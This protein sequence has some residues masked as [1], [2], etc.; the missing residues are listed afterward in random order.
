MAVRVNY[1]AI[2]D[3][4]KQKAFWT[5]CHNFF[6]ENVPLSTE[7]ESGSFHDKAMDDRGPPKIISIRTSQIGGKLALDLHFTLLLIPFSML[8][9]S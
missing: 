5:F 6:P 9:G 7:G 2:E 4:Q 3:R 1:S 8:M